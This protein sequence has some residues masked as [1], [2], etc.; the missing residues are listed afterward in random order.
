MRS[1]PFLIL[2]LALLG[3]CTVG[4]GFRGVPAAPA[5]EAGYA[6]QGGGRARLPKGREPAGGRRSVRPS[7][8]RWWTA[9]CPQTTA[10]PPAS[11]NA[12]TRAR[13]HR[14]R[15]GQAACRKSMPMRRARLP[16]VQPLRLRPGPTVRRIGGIAIPSSTSTPW[17][18][19]VSYDLDLFGRNR[20]ALEQAVAEAEAQQRKTEAAHLL[21]AGRVVTQVLAIAA[22]N[23]RIATEQALLAERRRNV[24]LTEARRRAAAGTL[25]EVLSAQGQL[26]GRSRRL[27]ATRT[28]CW[29]KAAPCWRCCWAFRPPNWGRP[30][31]ARPVH[32]ARPGAG[33]AAFG[34]GAQAARHPGSRSAAPR[35]HRRDRRGDGGTLSRRHHRRVHHAVDIAARQDFQ[36]QLQ[37]IRPVRRADRADLSRRHAQGRQA[38]RGGRRRG[39]AA[40]PTSKTVLEAFGQ[41]SNLLRAGNRRQVALRPAGSGAI[42]AER[43]L[44]LS[45]R[46]FQVGNSGILQVLDASRR[47]QRAKLDLLEARARQYHNVARLYVATAGGWTGDPAAEP[48]VKEAGPAS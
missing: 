34:A 20:R 47:Y 12:R 16:E 7:S 33:C 46:S 42:F 8:M 6:S 32:P 38:R 11:R 24:A 1:L 35:R 2:P 25:V 45:R 31:L 29:P 28:A 17:G 44:Y 40:R 15:G 10:S 37:R 48:E 43:S 22:L 21:V 27:P 14:R 23:D 19:G 36:Q 5:P 41:V 26:A 18:G 4:T 30:F 39:R 13:T 9:R 3:A